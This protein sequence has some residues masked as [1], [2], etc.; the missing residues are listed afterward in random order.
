MKT[1]KT[2]SENSRKICLIAILRVTVTMGADD[3]V[4]SGAQIPEM[5]LIT[6]PY[7]LHN[8]NCNI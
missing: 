1:R 5:L 3:P 2:K 7:L 8:I 6:C 4:K